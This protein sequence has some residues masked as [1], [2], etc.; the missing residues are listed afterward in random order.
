MNQLLVEKIT[1]YSQNNSD[2]SLCQHFCTPCIAHILKIPL[3][4]CTPVNKIKIKHLAA[5]VWQCNLWIKIFYGISNK[6]V[7]FSM[8]GAVLIYCI[9][10]ALDA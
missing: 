1:N 5:D 8:W 4:T 7:Y 9:L 3:H 6:L 10:G 2:N